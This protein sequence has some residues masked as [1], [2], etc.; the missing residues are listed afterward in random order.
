MGH[1]IG[2]PGNQG[3]VSSGIFGPN[4]APP[5]F[6]GQFAIVAMTGGGSP[7]SATTNG[8]AVRD[9]SGVWH[10]IDTSALGARAILGVT[11]NPSGDGWVCGTNAPGGIDAFAGS[12]PDSNLVLAGID[13]GLTHPLTAVTQDAGTLFWATLD[14]NVVSTPDL[15]SFSAVP[16]HGP[17]S[18]TGL[19]IAMVGDPV[20]SVIVGLGSGTAGILNSADNI[21]WAS[22]G[23]VNF[24]T[25][26]DSFV[27]SNTIVIDGNGNYNAV[28]REAG[29][30]LG[31]VSSDGIAFT[32]T[33]LNAVTTVPTVLA[34]DGEGGPLL[35]ATRDG[36]VLV[37]DSMADIPAATPVKV[38]STNITCAASI[39]G[40]LFLVGDAN[41]ITY[42]STDGVTWVTET[43]GLEGLTLTGAAS[44]AGF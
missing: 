44:T 30:G 43:T 31:A 40:P 10:L 42:T 12:V 26:S 29:N 32:L 19:G 33:T 18:Y 22:L 13:T 5:G 16:G 20:D 9:T 7:N 28:G 15:V 6:V 8:M 3:I 35:V 21:T 2:P 36:H 23:S 41:G 24:A 25:E 27:T 4:T 1:F 11:Q 39:P 37:A 34:N 17:G 14:N 38:S